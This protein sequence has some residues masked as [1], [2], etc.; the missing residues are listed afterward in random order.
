MCVVTEFGEVGIKSD[1]MVTEMRKLLCQYINF[2]SDKL[3]F[4][5]DL[6]M[7][8]AKIMS[9]ILMKCVDLSHCLELKEMNINCLY[10]KL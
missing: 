7:L 1:T 10:A 9:P 2:C 4:V 3:K 5:V 8:S 6:A